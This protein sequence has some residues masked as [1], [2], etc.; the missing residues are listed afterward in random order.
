MKL[1]LHKL[2]DERI[3]ASTTEAITIVHGN[4]SESSSKVIEVDDSI[5]KEYMKNPKNYTV[6]FEK[7]EICKV[8]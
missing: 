5:G 6:D 4:V 3:W 7:G 2:D 1:Y 8:S